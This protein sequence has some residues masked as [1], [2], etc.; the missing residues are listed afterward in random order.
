MQYPF[1]VI[2]YST[3]KDEYS[4]YQVTRVA[5]S[6]EKVLQFFKNSLDKQ[7]P[8]GVYVVMG[9]SKDGKAE[10]HNTVLAY[11]N[12]H[13]YL[14]IRPHGSGTQLK[15]KATPNSYV[16]G[17]Y[18]VSIFGYR[19]PDETVIPAGERNEDGL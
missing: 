6:Y 7:K 11:N 16:S 3:Y 19:L 12:E 17:H 8:I 13:N 18:V 14:E 4:S 10:A 2:E 15:L 1:K 9:L 5:E